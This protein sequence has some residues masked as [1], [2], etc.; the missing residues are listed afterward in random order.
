[1]ARQIKTALLILDSVIVTLDVH[2]FQQI[3]S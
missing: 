2:L 3:M 1:M